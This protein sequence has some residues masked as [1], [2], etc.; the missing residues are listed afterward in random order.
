[1]NSAA[2]SAALVDVVGCEFDARGDR[3]RALVLAD[4]ELASVP[5]PALEGVLRPEAGSAPEAVRALAADARTAPL[6]PLLVSGRGLRCAEHDA[7]ALL[8]ALTDAAGA[9]GAGEAGGGGGTDGAGAAGA[10]C[11]GSGLGRAGGRRAGA[12]GRGRGGWQP[13]LWVELATRAFTAGA[14]RLLV[15]TRALLGEGWDAPCV[16]C[17]VDLSSATTAMSVVQ[18]R[19]RAL[20]L[21]PATRTRS[22]PTGTSSASRRNWPVAPPTTSGSSASTCT[23]SPR[24]KT[25]RSRPGLRTCIPRSARS[26][27]PPAGTFDEIN[28]EMTG[29]AAGH[30]Q[31][32]ERW[33][34]GQPY[35]GA[36]QE[37][38]VVL[39][40][41]PARADRP[42]RPADQPPRYR[43][44][45][46]GA[47]RARRSR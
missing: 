32:R 17:L 41:R 47:G 34:I 42:P 40:R 30:E 21:D 18:S 23:C 1:M 4:A 2:K 29:R 24:P 22:P 39:P 5:A 45:A 26:R 10:N 44:P 28:R 15:G 12:P 37:T 25:A 9:G 38:L 33:G 19:G 35:A 13:R 36:E 20:R 31:A 14:T 16:N 11:G 7:D 27:P 43:M 46:Q 6:R 8:A 3:L